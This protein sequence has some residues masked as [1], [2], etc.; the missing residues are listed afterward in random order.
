MSLKNVLKEAVEGTGEVAEE[1]MSAV[2]GI[3]KE[4]AHDIADVFGAVIE[5]GKDGAIDVTEGV[6][7]TFVA[8][9]KALKESGKSTEDAVAE[10]SA[11]AEKAVG[12]IGEEGA[13]AVGGA[14][15]K[16]IEEAKKI[17]KTPFEK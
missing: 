9:V 14:A 1:L 12:K 16:G 5:L 10:V 4:G 11:G 13:E 7:S 2:T 15:K 6:K 17:V 8:A 3:V